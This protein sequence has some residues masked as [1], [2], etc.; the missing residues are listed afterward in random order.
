MDTLNQN[1]RTPDYIDLMDLFS[2]VY[3]KKRLVIIIT[4][5]FSTIAVIY[6]LTFPDIYT[7]KS[8]LAPSHQKDSLVSKMGNI[9][10]IGNFAGFGL[11]NTEVSKSEEAIERIKSYQFFNEFFL[12]N[13]KLE[14]LVA[15]KK[16]N[17]S[18][19]S[20]EYDK[21][22]FNGITNTWNQSNNNLP[23][24]QDAYKVYRKILSINSESRNSFIN[25]SIEHQSPV[26]AKKWLDIIIIQIN[27]SLRSA[28]QNQAQKSINYLNEVQK[29]INIESMKDAL[30]VLLE[31]QMQT[32]MLASSNENYVF[33][34]IDAPIAPE[35]KSSP[36]RSMISIIGAILG[37]MLTFLILF[38]D[39]LRHYNK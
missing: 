12:P 32:L 18:I 23:S 1:K 26:I 21:N 5:I 6:S 35:K 24:S 11:S 28:D 17:N 33:K 31:D 4:T 16:W 27:E 15:I 30:A 20:I 10:S 7:S 8:L 19:N 9:S 34:I 14:N 36:N 3:S 22:L 2:F 25:I 38:I 39:F 29:S 13:I 37:I